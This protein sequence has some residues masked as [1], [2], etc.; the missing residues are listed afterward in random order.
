M[1]LEQLDVCIQKINFSS[2]LTPYV[3][4]NSK[5]IIGLNVRA[6]T[7]KL[8]EENRKIPLRP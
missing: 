2:Y 6:K 5:W 1:V 7:I 3:K 4:I 8:L